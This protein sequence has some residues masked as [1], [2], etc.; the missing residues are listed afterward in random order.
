MIRELICEADTRRE[1]IMVI[2]VDRRTRWP[3]SCRRDVPEADERA[4]AAVDLGRH[5]IEF[6]T[7]SE[8]QF[9]PRR[10]AEVVLK[11]GGIIGKAYSEI[12]LRGLVE[13]GRGCLLTKSP[14]VLKK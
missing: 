11:V 1:I 2:V 7:Q 9:Q 5:R 3:K 14:T 6:V 12:G 4:E 13:K 8:V 10:N